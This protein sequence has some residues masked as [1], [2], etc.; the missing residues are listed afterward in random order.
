MAL[1]RV[2][3][4]GSVRGPPSDEELLRGF[5]GGSNAAL[6]CL[7]L[8]H[9]SA[10][11]CRVRGRL[12][13]GACARWE[14]AQD[15]V[16]TAWTKVFETRASGARWDDE[17]GPVYPWLVRIVDNCLWDE[18]RRQARAPVAYG[19]QPDAADPSQERRFGHV[20]V[21]EVVGSCMAKLSPLYQ[22][23]LIH[24]FW[25]GVNQAEIACMLEVSEATISRRCKE[26][27]D[28]L[29]SHL[30]AALGDEDQ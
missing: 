12:P 22:V 3:P 1:T 24:K 30:L 7:V 19:E 2:A 29:R 17:R 10:L 14:R 5:Y 15:V 23:I 9:G 6:D 13:F 8:R 11:E 16:A 18:L 20:E 21:S 26:A 4:D 27:C 25:V 28:M